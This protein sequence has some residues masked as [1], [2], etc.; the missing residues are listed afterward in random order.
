[1]AAMVILHSSLLTL[2]FF[3]SVNAKQ[4][5]R[6]ALQAGPSRCESDHGYQGS[7]EL[8]VQSAELIRIALGRINRG[9][10]DRGQFVRF[11]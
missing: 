7:A 3:G 9:S 6:P 8:R 1:M 5:E 11:L 10:G 4:L 2:N